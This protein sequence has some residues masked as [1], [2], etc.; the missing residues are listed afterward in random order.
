MT[1]CREQVL[2]LNNN[3]LSEF[4]DP[5]EVR[6]GTFIRGDHLVELDIS[7]NSIE[8][9]SA[10]IQLYSSLARFYASE[11]KIN[12]LSQLMG[13]NIFIR[14]LDMNRCLLYKIPEEL[15]HCTLIVKLY[16]ENNQLGSIPVELSH[17][18]VLQE[19]RLSHNVLTALP[20]EVF[21]CKPALRVLTVENN[22]L[23]E[24]PPSVYVLPALTFLDASYNRL[25][26]LPDD[27]GQCASLRTL[28]L[29]DNCIPALPASVADCAG[30]VVLEIHNNRLHSL[31][32]SMAK[33]IQ[34]RRLTI[35]GNC[36]GPNIPAVLS[37]LKTLPFYNISNNNIASKLLQLDPIS[38]FSAAC[39]DIR[40]VS[41][42][43]SAVWSVLRAAPGLGHRQ[44]DEGS[45]RS[46]GGVCS[47]CNALLAGYFPS[48]IMASG[49][50]AEAMKEYLVIMEGLVVNMSSDKENLTLA[51]YVNVGERQRGVDTLHT[52]DLEEFVFPSGACLDNFLLGLQAFQRFSDAARALYSI[53]MR[54]CDDYESWK[55]RM[56]EPDLQTEAKS[57]PSF[58]AVSPK[59]KPKT[60]SFRKNFSSK[61]VKSIQSMAE[62]AME[63]ADRVDN[64][65]EVPATLEPVYITPP[66]KLDITDISSVAKRL[67]ANDIFEG[68]PP[69]PQGSQL[70]LMAEA[71]LRSM[72]QQR[73]RPHHEDTKKSA[74]T[75]Y[76]TSEDPLTYLLV[77]V[78]CYSGLGTS[79]IRMADFL[80][81]LL[82]TIEE[83]GSVKPSCLSVCQRINDDFDDLM[84]EKAGAFARKK[85]N[86]PGSGGKAVHK[87]NIL[88]QL[89]VMSANS[90]GKIADIPVVGEANNNTGDEPQA[91]DPNCPLDHKAACAT[92]VDIEN[93]RRRVLLLAAVFLDRALFILKCC[94]WDAKSM[95]MQNSVVS[96]R[97]AVHHFGAMDLINTAIHVGFYYGMALQKL[98]ICSTAVREYYA[99]LSLGPLLV[100][101]P[102]QLE[103]VKCY[104]EMGEYLKAEELLYIIIDNSPSWHLRSD[105]SIGI[106][107]LNA[108]NSNLSREVRMLGAM[109]SS[110]FV[111]L[112]AAGLG[113]K[114]QINRFELESTGTIQRRPLVATEILIGR[115]D[116]LYRQIA[117]M[118]YKEKEAFAQEKIE[119][120]RAAVLTRVKEAIFRANAVVQ[121]HEEFVEQMGPIVMPE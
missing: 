93:Q 29:G 25:E 70:P 36:L 33:L 4:P 95:K 114:E 83:R 108:A 107:P 97:R 100:W 104:L 10:W 121:Q 52:M 22:L 90:E 5:S 65:L 81:S 2:K 72:L 53:C 80:C 17:L 11:N 21:E 64:A 54:Y 3:K 51:S 42:Y 63:A 24:L 58:K 69:P 77:L 82:R 91:L 98:R 105:K 40:M 8:Q 88:A 30:L 113:A 44:T 87:E 96:S 27:L 76:S 73:Q 48:S 85:F 6:T 106:G 111:S 49:Q 117:E 79:L 7:E 120:D 32:G 18:M 61:S 57:V 86:A 41:V 34:L 50:E 94:G 99:V 112:Q 12:L 28:L 75:V 78:D 119:L 31:P 60:V 39:R 9:V 66:T 74:R 43:V 46:V 71:A 15:G 35:H 116:R 110:A 19:L 13:G 47:A 55:L 102:L 89:K 84:G 56:N 118:K 38:G 68:V 59:G 101:H 115:T 20:S 14:E 37:D 67:R 23:S 16:L 26:V 109:L 62:G 103:I 92:A 1:L 45:L